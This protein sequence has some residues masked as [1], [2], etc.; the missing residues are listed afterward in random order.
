M[1]AE[2]PSSGLQGPAFEV[3][4]GGGAD[5]E[6]VGGQFEEE[7]KAHL[8]DPGEASFDKVILWLMLM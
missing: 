1:G 7:Q 4:P 3:Y 2:G 6:R 8:F 5:D